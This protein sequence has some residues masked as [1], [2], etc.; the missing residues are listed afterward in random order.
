MPIQKLIKGFKDFRQHND[1]LHVVCFDELSK[2]QSPQFMVVTCCDSRIDLGA[3]F[4]TGFGDL[5]VVRNVANIIPPYELDDKHH[6]TSAALE[7]GVKYFNV[8]HIILMGHSGCGGIR[9]LGEE[10][11][12]STDFLMNW[13]DQIKNLIQ[14]VKEK[15]PEISP[16][17]GD[18]FSCLE[19]ENVKAGL[20]RLS[21]YPWIQDRV[22]AGTLTLH[23][24]YF[25]IKAGEIL[26]V[27]V[28]GAFKPVEEIYG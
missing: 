16:R 23:G 19:K 7:A 5:F 18:Y 20:S 8:E 13:M 22:S 24:W 6:G 21:E 25:D 26:G 27:T 12:E 1:K 14:K 9:V 28:D 2:G 10:E 4:G 17:D 15:F 3:L 11:K